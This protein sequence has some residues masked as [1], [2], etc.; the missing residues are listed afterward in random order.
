MFLSHPYLLFFLVIVTATEFSAFLL[1]DHAN[2]SIGNPVNGNYNIYS[3]ID[4]L[5]RTLQNLETSVREKTTHMDTL[6]RQVLL[7]VTEID[8]NLGTVN[9]P[10]KHQNLTMNSKG[11]MN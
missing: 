6:M 10:D 5:E 11:R 1:N 4:A 8:S 7:T 3:K 2:A 9:L